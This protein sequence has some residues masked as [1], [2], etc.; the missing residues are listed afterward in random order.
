MRF[1]QL[2]F[3]L[4]EISFGADQYQRIFARTIDGTNQRQILRSVAMRNHF[5]SFKRMSDEIAE[6]AHSDKLRQA[7]FLRLLH[8]RNEDFL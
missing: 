2:H 8:G 6:V 1:G 5:P 7:C 4:A 3:F